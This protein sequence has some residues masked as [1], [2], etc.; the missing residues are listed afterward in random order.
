MVRPDICNKILFAHYQEI[1]KKN[2]IKLL[3]RVKR[4]YDARN[5]SINILKLVMEVEAALRPKSDLWKIMQDDSKSRL[6]KPYKEL[7]L[8]T[9]RMVSNCLTRIT[10]FQQEHRLFKE[11]FKFNKKEYRDYLRDIGLLIGGFLLNKREQNPALQENGLLKDDHEESQAQSASY[12]KWVRDSIKEF[13]RLE[14]PSESDISALLEAEKPKKKEKD[15]R[16]D[17]AVKKM[18]E[19]QKEKSERDRA[20]MEMTMTS[21]SKVVQQ[22]QFGKDLLKVN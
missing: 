16:I 11:E 7:V 14:L 2:V 21:K 10:V 3:L 8:K 13:G 17:K 1:T 12:E 6:A 9:L 20:E 22:M 4:L 15:S 5:E 18:R 19:A